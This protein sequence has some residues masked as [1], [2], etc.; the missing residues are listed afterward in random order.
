MNKLDII[1]LAIKNILRRKTRTVL[2][3]SGVVIGT[4]AIVVMMSIGLALNKS[5]E[6]QAAQWGSLTTIE[7]YKGYGGGVMMMGGG[8]VSFG[9]SGSGETKFD[10]TTVE[11]FEAMD[12]V[13][14]ASPWM[15]DYI[16]LVSG[17]YVAGVNLAAIDA[18]K[19]ELFD[20]KLQDGR[21]L[22]EHDGAAIVMGN[23]IP[24]NFYNPKKSGGMMWGYGGGS[25]A[26]VDPM[27]DSFKLTFDQSYGEKQVSIGTEEGEVKKKPKLY[28]LEVAG[29]L[30]QDNDNNYNVFMDYNQYIKMKK[31][32]NKTLPMNQRQKNI[33]E[34]STIKVKVD[35]LS[36]VVAVQDEIKAMGYQVY[37]L[38]EYVESMQQQTM[39]L[40]L[41]LGGLGAISLLVAALGITNTMIMSI[42][43]RTREIGIMKVI[44]CQVRDIRN[45]FLLEAAFIGLL[46]GV[47]GDAL[48]YGISVLLNNVAGSAAGDMLGMGG[49]GGAGVEISII[50]IW[51]MLAALGFST[52]IGVVSGSYP[53]WRATRLSALDAIKNE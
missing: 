47:I 44:G 8:S 48:S 41:I 40:R 30:Q 6:T 17:K 36:N 24:M 28:K 13:E 31:E 2:T 5:I 7:V 52:L 34:F 16:K 50:P 53:A 20:F 49:M 23:D 35:D 4:A 26:L 27:T 29:Y 45:S 43:E 22:D 10:M 38:M 1:R 14:A 25:D 9:G 42:Y 21:L 37:S 33:G 15:N 12:H 18:S 19:M 46:G 11:T 32:Y 39:T 3:V 51:L